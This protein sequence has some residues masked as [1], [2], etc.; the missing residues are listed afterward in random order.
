RSGFAETRAVGRVGADIGHNFRYPAQARSANIPLIKREAVARSFWPTKG[1]TLQPFLNPQI[2]ADPEI[3]PAFVEQIRHRLKRRMTA[4]RLQRQHGI[5][6]GEKLAG[7]GIGFQ[8]VPAA[9]SKS[10]QV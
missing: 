6:F 3:M 9:G 10:K 2:N 1:L 4:I 7:K 8:S 5:E